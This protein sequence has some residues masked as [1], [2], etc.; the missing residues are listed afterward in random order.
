MYG[1][2]VEL[3]NSRRSSAVV[4]PADRAETVARVAE[5]VVGAG[6]VDR[7]TAPIM[8]SEDFAFM[9]Q[10]RPGAFFWVG[11]G[12][13]GKDYGLHHPRYDFNDEVLPVGASFWSRLVETQLS[14]S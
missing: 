6:N 14:R 5:E 2:Q 12:A 10:A 9:L 7:D 11:Q 13:P 1:E 4:N 3:E 8:A